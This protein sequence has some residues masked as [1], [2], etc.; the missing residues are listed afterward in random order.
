MLRAASC[1]LHL[2]SLWQY[3]SHAVVEN[4]FQYT[5]RENDGTGLYYYRARYYSPQLTK[6]VSKDPIGLNGGA[7]LFSYVFSN[8]IN[9]IDPT[10]LDSTTV[11]NITGGRSM[12]FGPTNGNWGGMCWSGGQYSC[13]RDD[14]GNQRTNGTAPPL[15]SG[16]ICYQHH[17]HCYDRC[18]GRTA[19]KKACDRALVDE[20]N[21][22]PDD[23]RNWPSPPRPGTEGDST[24]YR[25]AAI[26]I[27][28]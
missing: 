17:D 11:I 14:R 13:G 4:P 9:Y 1:G 10:G 26:Y 23:P 7:N 19:C 18:R 25:R 22:L 8:P 6:F 21:G 3:N 5:G 28:K 24:N 20:L 15:D 16:D 12:F 2:R 27:K